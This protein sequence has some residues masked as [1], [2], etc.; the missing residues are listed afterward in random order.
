ML[1]YFKKMS[2]LYHFFFSVFFL[3][4]LNL[5]CFVLY[6]SLF[7]VPQAMEKWGGQIIKLSSLHPQYSTKDNLFINC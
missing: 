2:F 1:T 6:E 5:F 4:F 3:R 7:F